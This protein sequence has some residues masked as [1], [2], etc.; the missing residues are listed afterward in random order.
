MN[1]NNKEIVIAIIG[2]LIASIGVYYTIKA[3]Y[4]KDEKANNITN[5]QCEPINITGQNKGNIEINTPKQVGLINTNNQSGGHNEVNFHNDTYNPANVSQI[6]EFTESGDYG[7]NLLYKDLTT[8]V[9]NIEY[10]FKAFIPAGQ[11]LQIEIKSIS[12]N[13]IFW[14]FDVFSKKNW[15]KRDTMG[16][17]QVFELNNGDGDLSMV[18]RN[19]GKVNIKGYL[20]NKVVINKII[21]VN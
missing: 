7:L 1:E 10:S 11:N 14:Y 18:F 8:I 19:K 21:T 17:S 20:S 4:K 15:I 5:N 2:L 16:N 12:S 9:E 13:T 6:A 3:F